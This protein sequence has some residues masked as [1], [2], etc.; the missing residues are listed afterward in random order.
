MLYKAGLFFHSA[1]EVTWEKVS[2]IV[3]SEIFDRLHSKPDTRITMAAPLPSGDAAVPEDRHGCGH[4]T[5]READIA[6]LLCLIVCRSSESQKSPKGLSFVSLFLVLIAT[7]C[8]QS[9]GS[10]RRQLILFIYFFGKYT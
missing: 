2:D 3:C 10:S 1:L 6:M 4:Q 8:K 7:N 5:D 9:L